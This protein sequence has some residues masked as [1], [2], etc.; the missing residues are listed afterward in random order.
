MQ[1]RLKCEGGGETGIRTLGTLSSIHAF[2][3]CAFSHSAISPRSA[4]LYESTTGTAAKRRRL[5][6]MSGRIEC[7]VRGG[8]RFKGIWLLGTSRFTE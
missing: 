4:N 1:C 2:Q 7:K 6:P 5:E 3:A 8:N